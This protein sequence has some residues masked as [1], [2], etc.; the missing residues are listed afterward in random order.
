MADIPALLFRLVHALERAADVPLRKE[1]GLSYRRAV[2]LQVLSLNPD[3][4]QRELAALLGHAEASVS[5]LIR[6]LAE[7]GLV[8]VRQVDGRTKSLAISGD[9]LRLLAR[10][11]RIMD[12]KFQRLLESAAVDGDELGQSLSRLLAQLEAQ[13]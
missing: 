6:S 8:D 9:G 4:A 11:R 1:L 10:A 13:P 12:P 2:L 7:D 5:T 3:I